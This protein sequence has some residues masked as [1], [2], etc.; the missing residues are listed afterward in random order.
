MSSVLVVLPFQGGA[1]LLTFFCLRLWDFSLVS[2]LVVRQCFVS[3]NTIEKTVRFY[4]K[5]EGGGRSVSSNQKL[6]TV[7]CSVYEEKDRQGQDKRLCP[8]PEL[9]SL[10]LLPFSVLT[11]I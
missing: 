6:L 4:L 7:V 8:G 1:K 9:S 10:L 2:V 3:I 5:L 11:G